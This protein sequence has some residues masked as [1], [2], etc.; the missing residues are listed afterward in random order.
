[1]EPSFSRRNLANVG[2]PSDVQNKRMQ[3]SSIQSIQSTQSQD[4]AS[5]SCWEMFIEDKW[6]N[7]QTLFDNFF[8]QK[9]T[10]LLCI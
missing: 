1:M 5:W 8:L 6:T 10:Y 7:G 2:R 4:V 9:L 3:K